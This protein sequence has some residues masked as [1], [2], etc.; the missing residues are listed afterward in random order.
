[1][2]PTAMRGCYCTYH[3][4]FTC[5]LLMMMLLLL[6]HSCVLC[7]PRSLSIPLAK[8]NRTRQQT[9]EGGFRMPSK[10]F[11]VDGLAN[12][13]IEIRAYESGELVAE[14]AGDDARDLASCKL[15]QL[16]HPEP[17]V[18]R[19]AGPQ[20]ELLTRNP[21]R[22]R[23]RVKWV[24]AQGLSTVLLTSK[25]GFALQV[26]AVGLFCLGVLSVI[27]G[28]FSGVSGVAASGVQGGEL[29]A[30]TAMVGGLMGVGLGLY[31]LFAAAC[32]FVAGSSFHYR[33]AAALGG[34]A[35]ARA[36]AEG[37]CTEMSR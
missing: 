26:M 15:H 6:L 32:L 24:C 1:M 9:L 25:T 22:R 30:A 3:I 16:E 21:G 33:K 19:E 17:K 10:Y 29:D 8:I 36:Y 28:G 37:P 23:H 31:M 2:K 20:S 35:M 4:I 27:G 12:G 7:P 13:R 14:F 18:L 11:L 5:P 34:L